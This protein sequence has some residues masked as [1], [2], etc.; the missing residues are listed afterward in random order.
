MYICKNTINPKNNQNII[1]IVVYIR[2]RKCYAFQR[3]V[4]FQLSEPRNATPKHTPFGS[5]V[6][7]VLILVPCTKAILILGN[8]GLII[9]KRTYFFSVEKPVYLHNVCITS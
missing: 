7:S 1:S 5:F 4:S 2:L 6:F 3:N 8:I 9:F